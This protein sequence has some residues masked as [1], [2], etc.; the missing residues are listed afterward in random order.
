[1]KNIVLIGFMGSGKTA[2]GKQLGERLGLP[3]KDTDSLIEERLGQKINAIFADKGEAFFRDMESQIIDELTAKDNQVLSCG[4]GAILRNE[5]VNYLRQNGTLIY[6]KAPFAVLYNRIK[7]SSNR[8]LLTSNEPEK[9][10]R[11]LWEARQKVYESAAD[12]SL[13]TSKKSIEQIVKEIEKL[14]S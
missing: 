12:L 3:F 6:L 8:P 9:T 5:N 11:M 7:S 14:V 2:V 1:M 4:G 10:A 13:D